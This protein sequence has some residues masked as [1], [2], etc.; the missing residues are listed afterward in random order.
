MAT[1][2]VIF[3]TYEKGTAKVRNANEFCLVN[4]VAIISDCPSEDRGSIPL[5]GANFKGN[6]MKRKRKSE[7]TRKLMGV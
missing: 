4:I 3:G 2:V 7:K 6:K 5:R 1:S